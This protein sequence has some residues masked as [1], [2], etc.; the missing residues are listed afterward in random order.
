M[1]SNKNNNNNNGGDEHQ[2]LRGSARKRKLNELT[3]DGDKSTG[4]EDQPEAENCSSEEG[5]DL[6]VE[7]CTYLN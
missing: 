3:N 6:D 4:E 7:V 5:N 2:Q 1:E